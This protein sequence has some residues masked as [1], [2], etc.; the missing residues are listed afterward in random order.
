MYL[1]GV[2]TLVT[3][4]CRGEGLGSNVCRNMICCKKVTVQ[5]VLTRAIFCEEQGFEQLRKKSILV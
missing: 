5:K 1:S 3:P 4:V 2:F